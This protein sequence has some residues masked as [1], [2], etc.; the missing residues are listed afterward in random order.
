MRLIRKPWIW[1]VRFRHR[2][3]YGVHSP[4]A[5]NFLQSVIY[6]RTPYYAYADLNRLHPWWVRT[7]RAY[8][9][10]CRRLLFRLTNYIHP[11]TIAVLGHRPIEQA[12]MQAAVP[13][14][15]WVGKAPA[16]L[17]FVSNEA[18]HQLQLPVMPAQGMVIAE[19]IHRNR[20]SRQ[21]WQRLLSDP[22]TAV[23]FDLYDYG[24]IFFDHRLHPQHYIVNF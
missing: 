9:M 12:Y 13:G 14:A 22:Q 24:I 19:G 4:F 5:F 20:L 2:R 3:G 17:L 1:I 8:P 18:L 23:T 21:A 15:R 11:Q 16:D 6:E 10:Q 7:F